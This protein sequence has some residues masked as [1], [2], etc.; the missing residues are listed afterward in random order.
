MKSEV[1]GKIRHVK[2]CQIILITFTIRGGSRIIEYNN[3]YYITR[4]SSCRYLTIV[5]MLVFLVTISLEGQYVGKYTVIQL[6]QII[7]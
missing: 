5:A 4:I 6:P 2:L 7:L 3:S 1:N